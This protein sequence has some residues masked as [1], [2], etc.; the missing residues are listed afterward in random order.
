MT[1]AQSK[2]YG[3][4]KKKLMGAICMLLV[5]S[6]MVVSSTYAWFTLSTAPEITG[7]STSVGAN[8]NLEMA[9]LNTQT[10]ANPELIK[11]A[12]GDSMDAQGKSATEANVT[13]GNL[14]NLSDP[15]YGLTDIALYPAAL[16]IEEGKLADSPL[17]TPTYGSD[18]RVTGTNA[19][20]ASAIKGDSGWTIYYGNQDYG[21][22]AVGTADGLT[23]RQ[24]ALNNAKRLFNSYLSGASSKVIQAI[25][26][27]AGGLLALQTTNEG[28][29]LNSDSAEMVYALTQAV[30]TAV[31]DIANAYRQAIIAA[32]AASDS[33][34][35]AEFTM[36][37]AEIKSAEFS[38]LANVAGEYTPAAVSNNLAA[39]STMVT[40]AATA[41]NAVKTLKDS[42][43]STAKQYKDAAAK[44]VDTRL[45]TGSMNDIAAG[46][47]IENGTAENG[48]ATCILGD[49]ADLAGTYTTKIMNGVTSLTVKQHTDKAT[50]VK[51][52]VSGLTASTNTSTAGQTLNDMYGYII[53]FVFRTNAPTSN[54]QLQTTGV[55]RVYKDAEGADLAA[56]GAGS[57][58]SFA[59]ANMGEEQVKNIM[60]AVRVVF[61]NPDNGS[62]YAEA[63]IKE[64]F[65]GAG[66]TFKAPLYLID[67][68]TAVKTT[69]TVL[70]RDAYNKVN[71]NGDYELDNDKYPAASTVVNDGVKTITKYTNYAPIITAK[72]WQALPTKTINYVETSEEYNLQDDA[73][74][75]TSLTQNTAMKVSA[76]VFIDGNLV[77]N[78]DTVNAATA[79]ALS[80]NLQFSSSADLV[81]M[82]NTSL[83]EMVSSDIDA[84]SAKITLSEGNTKASVALG[85]AGANETILST[86]WLSSDTSVATIDKD[87]KVTTKENGE[88]TLV[89]IVKTERNVYTA[90][91]KLNVTTPSTGA[92]II[93]KDEQPVTSITLATEKNASYDK[94]TTLSL[95]L[96]PEKTTDVLDATKVVKWSVPTGITAVEVDES[97]GK[98]TAKDV[99]ES[100]VTVT[101]TYYVQGNEAE[102]KATVDVKVVK[103]AA[104]VDT[105][106][107][108]GSGNAMT[109]ATLQRE[110]AAV[111]SDIFYLSIPQEDE[112]VVDK[113]KSVQ[114]FFADDALAVSESSVSNNGAATITVT[115]KDPTVPGKTTMLAVITTEHGGLIFKSYT[116][117]VKVNPFAAGDISL[118]E[119]SEPLTSI[120]ATTTIRLSA[121]GDPTCD[122]RIKSV[123]W[124]SSD[125]SVATVSGT[126]ESATVTVVADSTEAAAVNKT[127]TI[128]A[129]VTTYGGLTTEKTTTVSVSIAQKPSTTEGQH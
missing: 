99:T 79:G 52:A 109:S 11:S 46:F 115:A 62:Y 1:Q 19:N 3:G 76:L 6:I 42:E 56:Q 38:N 2:S 120:G 74:A 121:S 21:V 106:D 43:G 20:T 51:T 67:S 24:I 85:N 15:S 39:V 77:D 65:T 103:A 53:D 126:N 14:I 34:T 60:R 57:Y 117:E 86:T 33:L 114:T 82:G 110:S 59:G 84:G 112:K 26:E 78:G 63:A 111:A 30:N 49:I 18:G 100:P 105:M 129:K 75:I 101:A 89:A 128:T 88:T 25:N 102:K 54:L 8:G 45:M 125:P 92:S 23:A 41:L 12:V 108:A 113:I 66:S 83:K 94:E 44:I 5:A 50:G 48:T 93:L 95:K 96:N 72:V 104:D 17:K 70:G 80:M 97:S 107:A 58:L 4:V 32:A 68:I 27:N 36:A 123:T 9:L 35:D 31:G 7:I 127:V 37:E 90:T 98:L 47:T 91:E 61:F 28:E 10:F 29:A 116:V 87:G 13:W 69:T 71:G 16:N 73:S 40:D 122:D 64:P 55:N 22:R 119:V 118:T 124:T 81:P